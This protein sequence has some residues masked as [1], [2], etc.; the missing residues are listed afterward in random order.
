MRKSTFSEHQISAVLKEAES[1]VEHAAAHNCTGSYGTQAIGSIT[2]ARRGFTTK[3]PWW[4]GD[5]A[6]ASSPSTRDSRG[7]NPLDPT[8][9][10]PSIS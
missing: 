4:C 9:A 10:G 3:R 2:R 7:C 5:G 6:V 8:D 1:G